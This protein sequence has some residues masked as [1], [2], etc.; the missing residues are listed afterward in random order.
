MSEA[1]RGIFTPSRTFIGRQPLPPHLWRNVPDGVNTPSGLMSI[2][3][4]NLNF[5]L[6]YCAKANPRRSAIADSIAANS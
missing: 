4:V 6:A 2:Y 5:Q 1:G 3:C